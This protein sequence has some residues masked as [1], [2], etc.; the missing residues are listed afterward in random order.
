MTEDDGF[1]AR[2]R[3]HGAKPPRG[4]PK[5]SPCFGTG[6]EF[7]GRH[8]SPHRLRG[9]LREEIQTEAP[10]S[11]TARRPQRVQNVC[12]QLLVASISDCGRGKAPPRRCSQIRPRG[13]R[14]RLRTSFDYLHKKI[15]VLFEQS[16]N[17]YDQKVRKVS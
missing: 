16:P 9:W 11:R 7:P 5:D 3:G 8:I 10:R 6:D 17:I 2:A 14:P 13:L 1:A 15:E 12:N 4:G